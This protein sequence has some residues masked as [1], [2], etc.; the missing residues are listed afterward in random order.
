MNLVVRRRLA[1][2]ALLA[3]SALVAGV[4]LAPSSS[5]AANALTIT[6]SA[7]ANSEAA[8]DLVFKGKD[9]DFELGGTAT[10]TRIGGG[11]TF[12]V[13][14]DP[15][16]PPAGPTDEGTATVD[17]TDM[18]DGLG[19][20]GP[21]DAGTYNVSASGEDGVLVGGG[22]D[23]CASC[24]T[25]LRAG[26]IALTSITPSS[27]RPNSKGN[28]TING[29]NFERGVKIEFLFNDG[30]VDPLITANELPTDSSGATFDDQITTPKQ[31]KR[32]ATVGA[33]APGSRG[34]RVTNLDGSTAS[35]TACFF[36]A[37]APLTSISPTGG[38]NDPSG[39]PVTVTFN[40]SDVVD[41]EPRLEFAGNPGS[42]TR[43]G[44]TIVGSKNA[45]SDG[46]SMTA[47]FDLRNAAPGPYQAVVRDTQSGVTNA[48][49]QPSCAAFTV[50]QPSNRKPP[51]VASLDRDANVSGAQKDQPQGTTR[52]F[53]VVGTNFSKGVVIAT[54]ATKT[55]VTGV[56]FVTDKLVRATLSVAK[57][58]T[59]GNYDVT[60]TLT[61]GTKSAACTGCFTVTAAASPTPSATSASPTACPTSAAPTAPASTSGTPTAS[62]S[63]S[64]TASSTAS[65]TA[66]ATASSTAS[67]TASPAGGGGLPIPPA[68]G[69]LLATETPTPTA[70]STATGT[71]TATASSTA[72]STPT[73]SSTATSTPTASSTAT[74]T[75]S[76]TSSP[77]SSCGSQQ[78]QLSV[79]VT[80]KDIVPT[81]ASTVR[82]HG[83]PNQVIDLYAYSRPNTTYSVVRSGTLN[84]NGDTSFT[85]TPG[86]NTR[87]YAHYRNGSTTTA[88]NDSPSTVITVHTSLSLSAYR[89]GV[90]KYHFQGTNLPRR[91][92]QLITL[93]RYAK[94]PNLDQ[95]CVP[96]AESDTTTKDDAGCTAVIT[97]QAKTGPNNT[98][99]INRTFTKNGRFY[100][101]VR[102]SENINNGRGHSNQRLTVIS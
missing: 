24:F 80:P 31:I 94:G 4:L 55:T 25:V 33:D 75:A 41:G 102:T 68:P 2:G 60:A 70:S 16:I 63:A 23:T 17:F 61:D 43:D 20:D 56:E 97:S 5:A 36:V 29:N 59:P 64:A 101:V 74:S 37:G 18:G 69:V 3:S 30:N 50:T 32:T 48:C 51:T 86:G 100:F 81:Q 93:Y 65:A 96:T 22:N 99:R 52:T 87:L 54:T 38:T 35:C 1:A 82:V 40:G 67:S 21:A 62:S 42:S 79:T 98:W 72:T 88:S 7:V 27:L 9:A 57:D 91:A 58:E 19:E 14:I 92:G 83:A 90:R 77:T 89:D 49:E 12:D 46:S 10:F 73:A 13:A 84:A 39:T 44:L 47:T 95:Y 8:Q 6:P 34:V 53:N 26:P 45:P 85:V 76:S 66:A 78:Q 28:I 71:P 11:K 15:P